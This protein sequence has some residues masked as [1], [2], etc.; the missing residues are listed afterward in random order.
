MKGKL[1]IFI[2]FLY[3]QF[4]TKFLLLFLYYLVLGLKFFDLGSII[5]GWGKNTPWVIY[6]R[7]LTRPKWPSRICMGQTKENVNPFDKL[8]IRVGTN[9]SRK[10]FSNYFKLMRRLFIS[11]TNYIEDDP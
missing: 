1:L 6:M 4:K 5:D 9:N 3:D 10:F 8:L 11:S 7:P 2:H